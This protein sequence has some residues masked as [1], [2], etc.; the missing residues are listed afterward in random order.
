MK[1]VKGF[2][3]YFVLAGVLFA[4]IAAPVYGVLYCLAP[5]HVGLLWGGWIGGTI[6]CAIGN[7]FIGAIAS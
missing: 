6:G 7:G 4:V 1:K 2:V 3:E 5:E